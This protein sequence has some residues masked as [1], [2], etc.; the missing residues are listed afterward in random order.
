MAERWRSAAEPSLP[1]GAMLGTDHE[2]EPLD[3]AEASAARRRGRGRGP[4]GGG[5]GGRCPGLVPAHPPTRLGPAPDRG[6]AAGPCRISLGFREGHR[7]HRP[8]ASLAA[9]RGPYRV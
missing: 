5:G 1:V 8:G 7:A 2:V 3:A 9:R 6:Y 4:G